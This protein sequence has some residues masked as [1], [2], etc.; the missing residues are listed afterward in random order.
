MKND[1]RR[2]GGFLE[3]FRSWRYLYLFLS[4]ILILA[5][6]YTEENWRGR[7]ALERY[8]QELTARG[9]KF[10]PSAFIPSPAP[11]S[12]NF[13]STALLAPLFDFQPG[14]QKWRDTNALGW[15][16]SVAPLLDSAKKAMKARV[17]VTSNSWVHGQLDVIASYQAL[18]RTNEEAVL[19]ESWVQK[20]SSPPDEVRVK[21]PESGIQDL[22]APTAVL[23]EA[24]AEVL[25]QLHDCNSLI[26]QLRADSCKPRSRF[27]IHYQEPNPAA[28]LL[29]HLSALKRLSEM[30]QL[31][32]SA[33]LV[34]GQTQQAFED[35][36]LMLYLSNACRDEPI[37]ISQLVRFAQIQLALEVIAYGMRQWSETQLD[38]LQARLAQFN[39]C[40]D[41]RR[42]LEAEQIFFGGGLIDYVESNRKE[43]NALGTLSPNN[44][45]LPEVLLAIIPRGWF[46]LEKL[47][48][49]RL[50]DNY[51]RPDL[52]DL[53]NKRINPTKVRE[54]R[55]DIDRTLQKSPESLLLRHRVF[56]RLLFP[57]LDGALRK[58]AFSQSGAQIAS[59]ACA[60]E[61]YRR[62]HNRFPDN[63]NLLIPQF[64]RELPTDAISGLPVHYRLEESGQYLLYSVGW[65]E[66]D[67]GGSVE[68]KE[69]G[70]GAA[71]E[72]DWVSR[73]GQGPAL[74]K[75]DWVWCEIRSGLNG[76][77]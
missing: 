45:Q 51:L 61:K 58:T 23:K 63:L 31:R 46:D 34:L 40:A 21:I 12:E 25:A 7:G 1:N 39:F 17:Q 19:A 16:Q 72:G 13:A 9:K 4:L 5:L 73:E 48:Y 52:I 59:I 18:L 10:E 26:E 56:A 37:L 38:E 32:V 20:T 69:K 30:L 57:S 43:Y 68:A 35:L 36:K 76:N 24:A 27:N 64:A 44:S 71:I 65:N 3:S 14:T 41:I 60:L 22:N 66:V 33:E 42:A 50:Y 77:R 11:N 2:K 29:P 74:I 55:L 6:F 62:A 49:Y 15:I 54:V 75:G 67:D 70:Q 53:S 8:K 28:I 47:N